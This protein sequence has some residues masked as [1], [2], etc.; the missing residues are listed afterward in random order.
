M[1]LAAE[2]LQP[3]LV[4]WVASVWPGAG[5]ISV[6]NIRVPQRKGNSGD[7]AFFDARWVADGVECAQGLAV[8]SQPTYGGIYPDYDFGREAQLMRVARSAGLNAPAVWSRP[9]DTLNGAPVI[10]MERC[11]GQVPPIM[12]S[13][14]GW[15]AELDAASQSRLVDAALGTIAAIHNTDGR[16]LALLNLGRPRYGESALDQ[17]FGYWE[18]YY[19]WAGRGRRSPIID[20]AL[21]WARENR[22]RD[23]GEVVLNWGDA[24]LGNLMFSPELEVTGVFDWEMASLGSPGLD[25]G[26]YLFVERHCTEAYGYPLPPGFPKPKATVARY[27]QISGRTIADMEF[28]EVWGGIRGTLIMLRIAMQMIERGLIPEDSRLPF[29]N[30]SS[31][32]L[33]DLIGIE[34]FEYETGGFLSEKAS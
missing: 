7:A 9:G 16:Q 34:S 32:L 18:A 29:E 12:F 21:D 10:V 31:A 20:R 6:S 24:K 17:E 3:E 4:R 25:L 11:E 15:V 1:P 8:R 26:W 22:P 23:D 33:A 28:Y 30:P 5:D 14:E 13:K 2:S 19:V 27:E